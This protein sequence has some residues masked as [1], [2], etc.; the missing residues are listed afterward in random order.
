MTRA[1]RAPRQA[2]HLGQAVGCAQG[3]VTVLI[4]TNAAY[5]IPRIGHANPAREMWCTAH[6]DLR[7]RKAAPT[8]RF[9]LE[10]DLGGGARRNCRGWTPNAG[11]RRVRVGTRAAPAP[12]TPAT[13]SRKFPRP[14]PGIPATRPG[15]PATRPGIPA[16]RPGIPVSARFPRRWEFLPQVPL[17]NPYGGPNPPPE[18]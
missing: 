17:K 7:R 1:G 15:I 6:I 10:S 11:L 13:T 12:E 14:R 9:K 3:L 4:N 16:T 8:L 18:S 2:G 5:C